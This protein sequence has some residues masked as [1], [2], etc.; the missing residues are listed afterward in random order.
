M[1]RIRLDGT[2][3]EDWMEG[4]K[5]VVDRCSRC[6]YGYVGRGVTKAFVLA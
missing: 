4:L 2:T 3:E 1:R 5:L 6:V